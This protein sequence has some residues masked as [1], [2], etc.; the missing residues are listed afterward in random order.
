[1]PTPLRSPPPLPSRAPHAPAD[2]GPA[3]PSA[4][5]Q[6][7]EMAA[8]AAGE[9]PAPEEQPQPVVKRAS[10]PAPGQPGHDE[11]RQRVSRAFDHVEQ[12]L[13]KGEYATE[14]SARQLR[15]Q[16]SR[17]LLSRCCRCR[18]RASLASDFC[19]LTL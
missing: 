16:A 18:C 4:S 12:K 8:G 2:D 15:E 7:R 19:R 17:H 14:I 11:H 1:M 13:R 6:A 5:T 9:A 3:V 10:I